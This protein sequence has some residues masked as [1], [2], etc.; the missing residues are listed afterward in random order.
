MRV[1]IPFDG[2][3]IVNLITMAPW[4]RYFGSSAVDSQSWVESIMLDKFLGNWGQTWHIIVTRISEWVDFLWDAA[5][6]N[7]PG[8][9]ICEGSAQQDTMVRYITYTTYVRSKLIE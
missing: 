7:S 5:L 8:K 6:D 3:A 2:T 4:Q 9:F 1:V